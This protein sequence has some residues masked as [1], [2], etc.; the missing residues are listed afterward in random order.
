MPLFFNQLF[1]VVVTLR[2]IVALSYHFLMQGILTGM[3]MTFIISMRELVAGLLILP[4]SVETGANFI[5]SQFEQGN[6]GV[7]WQ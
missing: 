7:E 6:V 3:M 1:L 4:P 5:Y 2:F